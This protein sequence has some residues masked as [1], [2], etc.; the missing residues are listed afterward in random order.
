MDP[1][2]W[3]FLS[4]VWGC[5]GSKNYPPDAPSDETECSRRMNYLTDN[6]LQTQIIFPPQLTGKWVSDRCEVRTGPLYL[7]RS[8]TFYPNN[9]FHLLQYFYADEFCSYITHVV[10]I[11]GYYTYKDVVSSKLYYKATRITITPHDYPYLHSLP[12]VVSPEC[13]EN[14]AKYWKNFKEH[15]VLEQTQKTPEPL[16]DNTW[17]IRTTIPYTRN[18]KKA[19]SEFECLSSLNIS[20]DELSSI[21]VQRRPSIDEKNAR[22]ELL[23]GS[24]YQEKERETTLLKFQLPLI[25]LNETSD[26]YVC[27][28]IS[29]K[30]NMHTPVLTARP[31]LPLYFNGQWISQTCEPRSKGL[32]TIRSY[33]F[34]QYDST[35][36]LETKYYNNYAC[37]SLLMIH[38]TLGH[39]IQGGASETVSG[40]TEIAFRIEKS[41]LTIVDQTIL[42]EIETDPECGVAYYWKLNVRKEIPSKQGCPSIGLA[43]PALRYDIIKLDLDYYHGSGNGSTY[44][45]LLGDEGSMDTRNKFARPTAFEYPVMQC[46]NEPQDIID[47]SESDSDTEP[48]SAF[49]I[50]S[51]IL[52]VF[53]IILVV[54]L[55]V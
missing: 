40:A 42:N 55:R 39:Y 31:T 37:S 26:C 45:L 29:K 33:R 35:W 41:Y 1:K 25:L 9:T 30:T 28:V 8:Y 20:Y 12:S 52:N 21:R 47:D 24:S 4:I 43:N 46:D 13:P 19:V 11:K 36:E 5:N 53:W 3:I 50:R 6:H 38:T 2:F 48:S 27:N 16:E 22:Y 32:H 15:V 49:A 18:S 23:L 17:P 7:L 51:E 54:A 34:N 44:I 10:S 14:V